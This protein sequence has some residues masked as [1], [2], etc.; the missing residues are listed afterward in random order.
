[1]TM[2]S[3]RSNIEVVADILRMGEASR[4]QIMYRAG[5]SYT[6]LNKYLDYLVERGFLLW[7][8]EKYPSGVYSVRKDG[9]LLLES[10]EKIEEM[11]GFGGG[12][13]LLDNISQSI[14][15]PQQRTAR[16]LAGSS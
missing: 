12:E 16:V 15:A 10:I 1:M 3:R 6:Q 7:S 13:G 8:A 2:N 11:L 14:K 4:T 9:E 5:M